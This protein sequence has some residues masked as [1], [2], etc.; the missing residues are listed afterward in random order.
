MKTYLNQ[1]TYKRLIQLAFGLYFFWE[2]SKH[3]STLAV[4]FG[5]I[6]TFQAIA[7]VG[8]FSTKGCTPQIDAKA[9]ENFS[10]DDEIDFE[11]IEEDK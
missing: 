3:P 7:N 4:I 6:M 8:C 9:K 10:E 11:E 2:Y 5:S 1:W